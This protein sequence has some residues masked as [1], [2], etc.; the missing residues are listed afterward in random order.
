[1]RTCEYTQ[2]TVNTCTDKTH[3]KFTRPA[4][5]NTRS[6]Q[7]F[8]ARTFKHSRRANAG[9]WGTAAAALTSCDVVGLVWA[10]KDAA[11]VLVP[12]AKFAVAFPV[13]YHYA[14]GMRHLWWDH[15]AKNLD[16]KFLYASSYALFGGSIG[17]SV[18]LM[19]V[20]I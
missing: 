18:V 3:S 12:V 20:S 17:L 13:V 2:H 11:P 9:I 4:A 1:M 8:N 5:A 6:S 16:T 15:T 7:Q 14:A 19:F 10:F